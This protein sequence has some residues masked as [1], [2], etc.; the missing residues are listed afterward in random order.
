MNIVRFLRRLCYYWGGGY[1]SCI[2]LCITDSNTTG[3]PDIERDYRPTFWET[4]TKGDGL[5]N[6]LQ[7]DAA[8]SFGIGKFASFIATPLRTVLYS[9]S[10]YDRD[11]LHHR[12][13]GKTILVSHKGQNGKAFQRTGYLGA[14]FNSLENE[15]IPETFKLKQPGTSIYILGYSFSGG[16]K[17]WERSSTKIILK[18]YFH[19]IIHGGLEVQIGERFINRET[20]TH[21]LADIDDN[22][23]HNFAKVSLTETIDSYD[24]KDVGNFTIRIEIDKDNRRREIALVRDAGMLI[25]TERKHMLPKLGRIPGH[26]WG[27][28][29]VIECKSKGQQLLKQ[30]ESPRHD[31]ISVDSISNEELR[32]EAKRCLDLIGEWCYETIKGLA[33]PDAGGDSENLSELSGYLGL[34]G[35]DH[36]EVGDSGIENDQGDPVVTSPVQ[37]LRPPW[38]PKKL[39]ARKKEIVHRPGNNGD[40][41]KPG[42]GPGPKPRPGPNPRPRPRRVIPVAQSFVGIR[43]RKGSSD[44]HS[45]VVTFDQPEKHPTSID[46]RSVGEDGL[47]YPIGI[48]R[49]VSNN[50]DLQVIED[51]IFSIPEVEPGNRQTIE[52]FTREP[53]SGKSFS[54]R[55][56]EES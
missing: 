47:L 15:N 48:R 22:S 16:L 1:P 11:T 51:I 5:T 34:E 8:G 44:T 2:S 24:M 19:A 20:F 3:A 42:P 12:F 46:I 26:W 4:L 50:R 54:L 6:K 39:K 7:K 29:A 56:F 55:F 41:P 13:I 18:N 10:F 23:I 21:Y 43:F 17:R 31:Q 40:P 14:G 38:K 33:E 30:A 28:T 9:T 52:I 36:Q 53:I 49:A 45:V 25:T 32:K 27:F 37:S 35:D